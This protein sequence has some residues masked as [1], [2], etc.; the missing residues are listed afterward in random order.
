MSIKQKLVASVLWM[1]GAALF[2][3]LSTLIVFVALARI[4]TPTEFG[5]VAFAGIFIDFSRVLVLAGIPDALIQRPVWDDITA[6]TAFWM[7]MTISVVLS[8][9]LVVVAAPLIATL[10]DET[11]GLVLATMA[12]ILLVE[13]ATTVHVAQLRREFRH[14]IIARRGIIANSIGG[15]LGVTLA[16]N[17]WGVWS[18]VISRLLASITTSAILLFSSSFRPKMTFSTAIFKEL[19]L[20]SSPILSSQLLNQ[21]SA[22]TPS[23]LIGIFLGPFAIAQYRVG[24]RSL[25]LITSLAVMPIQ[26][27]S[28][29]ALSRTAKTPGRLSQAYL[30]LTRICGLL[31]CPV[32]LGLA[33]VAP[34]FVLVL[35]GSQWSQAGHVLTAIAIIALP[36]TLGYF[37][38][39]TLN[40]AGRSDLTFK[41]SLVASLTGVVAASLATPFGPV[42]VAAA[43]TLRSH[44]TMPYSVGLVRQATGVTFHQAIQNILPS[45]ACAATMAIIVAALRIG[46]FAD[47]AEVMRLLICIS[48]GAL[49]YCL[50]MITF[51]R[52][53][54]QTN[55]KDILNAIP[56]K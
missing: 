14:K 5:I 42:C 23:L 41:T 43:L 2:N 32:L 7:N 50:L 8:L 31:T 27:T 54:L 18:I 48:A 49:L 12:I 21:I 45:Y 25:G 46:V 35:F 52:T 56:K 29:S 9:I 22:Q 15:L 37:E 51:A 47:M 11:F 44:L 39:P 19:F 36:L 4:L 55:L 20:F 6:S 17:G 16:F 34:D 24:S 10:Y 3:N 40:A 13:G 30:R 28:I 26:S 38:S 33:A 53:Y 1:T